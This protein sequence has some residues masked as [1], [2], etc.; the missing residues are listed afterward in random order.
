MPNSVERARNRAGSWLHSVRTRHPNEEASDCEWPGCGGP[1]TVHLELAEDRP[2]GWPVD[3]EACLA[4]GRELVQLLTGGE[5]RHVT[6]YL[7]DTEDYSAEDQAQ[8]AAI[9]R[10]WPRAVEWF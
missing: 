1:G 3:G 2:E 8:V 9:T 5:L 10:L 7:D 6:V 4:H